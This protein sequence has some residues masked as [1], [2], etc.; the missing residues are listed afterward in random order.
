[1]TTAFDRVIGKVL[2]YASS[3]TREVA[4]INPL[5]IYKVLI[6]YIFFQRTLIHYHINCEITLPELIMEV[7][8]LLNKMDHR[9][10]HLLG[11]V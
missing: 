11:C 9:I 2:G 10:D 4:I 1:M 8:P 3:L 6:L 5:H 7:E